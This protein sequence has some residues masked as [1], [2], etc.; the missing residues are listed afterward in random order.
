MLLDGLVLNI[1]KVA[2]CFFDLWALLNLL[3]LWIFVQLKVF[4]HACVGCGGFVL[5][6][7][8]GIGVSAFFVRGEFPR[9]GCLLKFASGGGDVEL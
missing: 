8:R 6:F 4:N 3:A 7:L 1:Q 5:F 9:I 2:F